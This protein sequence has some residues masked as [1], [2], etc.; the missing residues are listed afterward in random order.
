V[1]TTAT[2]QTP[3]ATLTYSGTSFPEATANNGSITQTRTITLA[4][5]TYVATRNSGTQ[6]T[7]TGVPT[8]LT[9]VVTRTSSTV[10]TLSFTGNA[11]S[12]ANANDTS[13]TFTLN[14][15]AFTLGVL[16]SGNSQSFT[17]D[18]DDP[19]SV[20]FWGTTFRELR[21]ADHAQTEHGLTRRRGPWIG[22]CKPARR[23]EIAR[24]GAAIEANLG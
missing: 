24:D 7:F 4:N 3:A 23:L 11:S 8:G 16:P 9:L 6:Y 5:D 2:T 13:I 1:T 15:S 20:A 12:H 19:S 21:A 10:L 17:I 22:A 18:F 14:A